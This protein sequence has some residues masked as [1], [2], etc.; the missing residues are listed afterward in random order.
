MNIDFLRKIYNEAFGEEDTS[1]EE[2]LFKACGEYILT[3]DTAAM[4]FLLP[5]ELVLSDGSIDGFYLFAAA[6]KKERRGEGHMKRLIERAKSFKKPIFL[7]PAN[8]GLIG[9]YESLGFRCFTAQMGENTLRALPQGGF[10]KLAEGES[11]ENKLSYTA[12]CVNIAPEK[13]NNLYF[14]YVME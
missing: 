5:T 12:M 4:L 14:P 9:F 1:F 13:L 3:D 6:T 11:E 7:K 10:A 8:E 2:S